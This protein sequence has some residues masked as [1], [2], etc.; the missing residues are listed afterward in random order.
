MTCRVMV[1]NTSCN[2][3]QSFGGESSHGVERSD[4]LRGHLLEGAGSDL[5]VVAAVAPPPE[6]TPDRVHILVDG[7][8]VDSGGP[9]LAE[10]LEREGYEGW[11]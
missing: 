2:C 8:I 4:A 3:T 10:R 7:R 6:L 5:V 9:E 11:R 1:V